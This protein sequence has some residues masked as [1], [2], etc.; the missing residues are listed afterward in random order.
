MLPTR[1]F[2][3][4]FLSKKYELER[5]LGGKKQELEA[6]NIDVERL[7]NMNEVVMQHLE[8]RHVNIKDYDNMSIECHALKLDIQYS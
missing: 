1:I 3:N 2:V 7:D 6:K 8:S 4:N 5:C